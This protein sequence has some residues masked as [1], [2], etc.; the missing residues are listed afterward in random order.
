MDIDISGVEFT[1]E[2]Y[3][4]LNRKPFEN[5]PDPE[6]MYKSQ[7]HYDGL[8]MLIYAITQRRGAAMLTGDIGCG[9]TLLSRV[10][11]D[12]LDME[13][14]EIAFIINPVFTAIELLEKIV[15]EFGIDLPASQESSEPS[16]VKLS[17]RLNEFLLENMQDDK[18]ALIII[19]EAQMIEDEKT[20]DEIRALLNFQ[21]NERFLL[22][23]LLIGQ[24]EL[25][26]MVKK[27]PQLEQRL[28]VRWHL[29]PLKQDEVPEY[30]KHR[31][32]IAGKDVHTEVFT[33][34]AINL[35]YEESGGVPRLINEICDTCL[36]LGYMRKV[37]KIDAE[38]AS[39]GIEKRH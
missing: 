18:E 10:L 34:E 15:L 14:Y 31:L 4:E 6:F 23:L 16:R 32:F 38:L 19:D 22:T 27:L 28:S 9:K 36:F 25:K 3:W 33:D 12:N 37:N 13:K 2:K 24:P 8:M 11:I 1:Y 7:E 5:T 17:K 30:I 35:I 20:L 39:F 29:S 21:L 26:G